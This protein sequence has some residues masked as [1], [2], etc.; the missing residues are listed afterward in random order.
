MS[1]TVQLSSPAGAG[2][3]HITTHPTVEHLSYLFYKWSHT[4]VFI[5]I[6]E[7]MEARIYKIQ[8]LLQNYQSFNFINRLYNNGPKEAVMDCDGIKDRDVAK[9]ICRSSITNIV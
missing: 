9:G 1:Q 3:L 7:E 8:S 4:Y 5:L 2:Q 6:V